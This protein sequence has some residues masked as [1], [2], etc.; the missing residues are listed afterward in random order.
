MAGKSGFIR[1][2]PGLTLSALVA[3]VASPGPLNSA[4]IPS[5][6]VAPLTVL[7][8]WEFINRDN[9]AF[10]VARQFH[11][12][13]WD[14]SGNLEFTDSTATTDAN[15][16]FTI[17]TNQYTGGDV[18]VA[19]YAASPSP[20]GDIVV[21]G[22]SAGDPDV[23]YYLS[24]PFN[25]ALN[26]THQI[27]FVELKLPAFWIMDDFKLGF[28]R[29]PPAQQ[30]TVKVRARWGPTFTSMLGG[31]V[32]RAFF[33]YGFIP[34]GWCTSEHIYLF[35]DD[36]R[37]G[38]FG[39]GRPDRVPLHEMGHA[40]M[41]FL[42]NSSLPAPD[43]DY[44]DLNGP[45]PCGIW[46]PGLQLTGNA[47]CAW[48][49]G[50]A[51]WWRLY[52]LGSPVVTYLTSSDDYEN[53]NPAWQV[54][55]TTPGRLSA[56]LWDIYDSPA[57]PA[58]GT[59]A[60]GLGFTPIWSAFL[61]GAVDNT[62]AQ[63]WSSWKAALQNQC[64]ATSIYQNTITY[65]ADGWV[66]CATATPTVLKVG[67]EE[68]VGTRRI[69][70]PVRLPG[71]TSSGVNVSAPGGISAVSNKVTFPPGVIVPPGGIKVQDI[72]SG[73]LC[74]GLPPPP[75]GSI[76]N[77]NGTATF[78]GPVG[79]AALPADLWYLYLRLTGST[80]VPSTLTFPAAAQ[81]PAQPYS[82]FATGT[83]AAAS[84]VAVSRSYRRGD[85]RK[86]GVVNNSD[87][88][89]IAQFLAGL[90]GLGG[91]DT[92]T[93]H[94]VNAASIRHDIEGNNCDVISIAD[95]L[96]IAQYLV[97]LRDKFFNFLEGSA[98]AAAG[99]EQDTASPA[100]VRLASDNLLPGQTLRL[101]I[102]V[103]GL[104]DSD[105]LGAYDF[106]VTFNPQTMKVVAVT[107]GQ[108]PFHDPPVHRIDDEAGVVY[109]N[110]VQTRMPGPT[111]EMVV[112][113]LVVQSDGAARGPTTLDLS[114]IGLADARNGDRIPTT[115]V[116]ATI[117][118]Q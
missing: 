105:G 41:Y 59:D 50:W 3:V 30:G 80:L 7:G 19:L 5:P 31:Q 26:I 6:T 58:D 74:D 103:S 52:A 14:A 46:Q 111:G 62:F 51:D 69:R 93:V 90:R 13:L 37:V 10:V 12:R 87:D 16:N 21:Q 85:A 65:N 9:S 91:D 1:A 99:Q 38:D 20:A 43:T 89:F 56:A 117:T 23:W 32:S 57:G 48:Q 40:V 84:N 110:A 100:S 2:C 71:L 70:T 64:A 112:A 60:V 17:F 114:V 55:D 18:R 68:V 115:D 78:T 45:G 106:K 113:H 54:G 11:T 22:A 39:V 81:Q 67:E 96:F 104:T 108:S 24:P 28:E 36:V 25:P 94:G 102:T 98:A 44:W 101:P 34:G 82:Y 109:L 15:G 97:G 33:C 76:D 63:Y 66:S 118:I 73:A 27:Q 61:A 42:Y 77:V 29:I 49:E 92:L 88:L 95:R 47:D 107:G 53:T 116:D 86:D 35:R 4:A 72:T 75:P 8:K 83:G 79:P